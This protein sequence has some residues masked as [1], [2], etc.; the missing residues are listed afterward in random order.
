[1]NQA[2]K[3]MSSRDQEGMQCL[4]SGEMACLLAD[5]RLHLQHGPID[6]LISVDADDAAKENAF[7]QAKERFV[8][9]L[10]SLANE[11]PLL[12]C[13]FSTLDQTAVK[14]LVGQRMVHAVA[15]FSRRFVTPMAAVAGAV[16]DEI[17][18]TMIQAKQGL[19]R[20]SI[21]NGG[22]IALYL[23][24]G[25]SYAIGTCNNPNNGQLAGRF[26][27]TS[28]DAVGG[29]ATSGWRGRSH[30]L[31]IAD[32][33]TV[34][35]TSAAQADVAATLIANEVN[36]SLPEKIGRTLAQ[37]LTPDTDLTDIYVT[38]S[39]LELSPDEVAEALQNGVVIAQKMIAQGLIFSALLSLKKSIRVVG[40]DYRN[41]RLNTTGL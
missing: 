11:L 8:G 38:T 14:G 5:G 36:L 23:A 25:E 32:A 33:V 7:D 17:L 29:V 15:K 28:V 39:V 41:L 21:N 1:M 10:Q 16:A 13:Q 12:R 37:E 4:Q 34:L 18:A 9:L 2:L 22:D 30:S 24:P 3:P 26:T 20:V 27:L 19:R 31:G 6:L 40:E 35:A